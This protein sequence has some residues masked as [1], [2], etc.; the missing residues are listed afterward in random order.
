MPTVLQSNFVYAGI[1]EGV[2]MVGFADDQ[3]N[4]SEYVLLQMSVTFDEQDVELGMDQVHITY[5]EEHRSN[6]GGIERFVLGNGHALITLSPETAAELEVDSGIEIWFPKDSARLE[7]V[8]QHLQQMFSDGRG[9]LV[10][11]G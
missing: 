11:E 1:D 6:Y 8:R 3:F 5:C 10:F 7:S 2:I 4:T 9:E